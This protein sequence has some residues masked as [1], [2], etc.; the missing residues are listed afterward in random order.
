MNIRRAQ[1]TDAAEIAKVHVKSWQQS[2]RGLIEDDYLSQMSVTER[3]Q[4]W[5]E[6]LDQKSH[7]VLVLEDENQQLCGFISGG[8]IRSQH[9]YESEVY[10]FYL[11]KEVQQKGHGTKLLK[12]FS[13][14][15]I[16]LGK[17]SM[18]VWV[19][20]DNPSK[21]A[22]ISLGGKKIDEEQVMIGKQQLLEE[23]FAWDDIALILTT[24]K[25][26]TD[27]NT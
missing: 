6:W 12:M 1:I 23:C 9:Q 5:S 14:K 16:T 19:L 24:A 11:L 20:K 2:Y 8:S 4:R 7:I 13:E 15:L 10:A 25:N 17:K 22:Y 26:H 27:L 3:E 21:Q 18:I